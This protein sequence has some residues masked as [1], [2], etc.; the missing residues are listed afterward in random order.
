MGEIV[1][2]GGWSG[3]C[4]APEAGAFGGEDA[5][6]GIFKRDRFRSGESEFIDDGLIEIGS[7]FAGRHILN[8]AEV[9]EAFEQ[10][11]PGEVA[12]NVSV[13]G[14]RRETDLQSASARLLEIKRDAGEDGL[15]REQIMLYLLHFLLEGDAICTGVAGGP[16]V[17]VQVDSA[18]RFKGESPGEYFSRSLVDLFEGRDEAGFGVKN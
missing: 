7:G 4:D 16:R 6:F 2:D 3:D 9:I 18:H 15:G 17:K 1:M 14:I 10:A 8:A 12:F 13:I 5:V 11:E